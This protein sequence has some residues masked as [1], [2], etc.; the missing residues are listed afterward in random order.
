MR[1]SLCL[2]LHGNFTL[3]SWFTPMTLCFLLFNS[4]TFYSFI[5][6]DLLSHYGRCWCYTSRLNMNHLK[7]I[8]RCLALFISTRI[9][10]C[11]LLQLILYHTK[12]ILKLTKVVQNTWCVIFMHTDLASFSV[13]SWSVSSVITSRGKLIPVFIYWFI[14]SKGLLSIII[15]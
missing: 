15:H 1:N 5:K 8:S 6:H 14:L 13:L 4:W 10:Y 12:L 9:D 3:V 11:S 7:F 2:S